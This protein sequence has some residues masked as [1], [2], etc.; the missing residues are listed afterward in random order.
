MIE[1]PKPVSPLFPIETAAESGQVVPGLAGSDAGVE[2]EGAEGL[3]AA[4]ET[5]AE[6][7][8]KVDEEVIPQR[9]QA[10]PAQ[11]SAS[12][13]ADHNLTHL[14]YRAWCPD[15]VE[16][17]GRERSHHAVD[18]SGR[19]VPLVAVDYCFLAEKGIELKD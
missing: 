18:P 11:P 4:A 3:E 10:S 2:A 6:P 9:R 12:E 1:P 5:A 7:S 19:V 15:C 13:V 8:G 16:A 17:F 14:R